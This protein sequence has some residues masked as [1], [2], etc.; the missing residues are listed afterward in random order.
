MFRENGRMEELVNYMDETMT[1]QDANNLKNWM[2][3]N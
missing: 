2:L 1:P 3:K